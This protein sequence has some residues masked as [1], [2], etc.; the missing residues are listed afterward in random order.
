MD[1]LKDITTTVLAYVIVFSGIGII[2]TAVMVVPA[3]LE[4]IL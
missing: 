1:R 2:T 3:V 4:M